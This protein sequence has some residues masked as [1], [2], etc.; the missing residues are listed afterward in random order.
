MRKPFLPLLTALAVTGAFG[1]TA[2]AGGASDVALGQK[3][4]REINLTAR[5]MPGWQSSPDGDT[6]QSKADARQLALCAGA[7]DPAKVIVTHINSPSFDKGNLFVNSSVA[8]VATKAAATG[9]LAAMRGNKI[10]ECLQKEL[11]TLEKQ[12]APARVVKLGVTDHLHASW[13]P[14]SGFGYRLEVVIKQGKVTATA[15]TDAYGFMIGRTQV[16]LSVT[17]Q[18]GADTALETQLGKLLVKRAD[19]FAH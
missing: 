15:Y 4:A 14:S 17:Y 6:P 2:W 12:V 19:K 11:P 10:D 8:L 13:L 7:P 1:G 3:E 18:G 16:E 5:D 9:T